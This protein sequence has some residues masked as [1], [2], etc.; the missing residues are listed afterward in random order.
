[1]KFSMLNYMAMAFAICFLTACTDGS[2][3]NSNSETKAKIN[4]DRVTKP[5]SY[6]LSEFQYIPLADGSEIVAFLDKKNN[7]L[8]VSTISGDLIDVLDFNK[9][10]HRAERLRS[11]TNSEWV[12]ISFHDFGDGEGSPF[13][14]YNIIT[15]EKKWLS[16]GSPIKL[17]GFVGKD[18]IAYF[19]ATSETRS[20]EIL[21]D[22]AVGEIDGKKASPLVGFVT[23]LDLE[24]YTETDILPLDCDIRR[25]LFAGAGYAETFSANHILVKSGIGR[26]IGCEAEL[27]DS[28]DHKTKSPYSKPDW[29]V[30]R[31]ADRWRISELDWPRKPGTLIQADP[32]SHSIAHMDRNYSEITIITPSS[33]DSRKEKR[34]TVNDLIR[35]RIHSSPFSSYRKMKI[36]GDRAFIFG[37]EADYIYK[38]EVYELDDANTP[39]IISI[40][41]IERFLWS[42]DSAIMKPH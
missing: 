38:F 25:V 35:S 36:F 6:Y 18:S 23:L 41:S 42:K 9:Y 26:P 8:V 40:V 21:N 28:S 17:I 12:A 7:A 1:M 19:R 16:R 31:L 4:I 14:I 22:Y 34:F 10:S 37:A 33:V 29:L 2:T 11:A 24:T 39:P 13:L 15:K 5:S 27:S 30:T 20:V 32:V 3:G